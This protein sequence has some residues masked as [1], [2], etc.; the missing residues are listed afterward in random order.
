[1]EPSENVVCNIID[2]DEYLKI[3]SVDVSIKLFQLFKYLDCA[4]H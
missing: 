4:R 1:M 3:D 2:Y